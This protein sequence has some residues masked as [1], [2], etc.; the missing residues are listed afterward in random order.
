[1]KPDGEV[2]IDIKGNPTKFQIVKDSHPL[3]GKELW[4]ELGLIAWI[5]DVKIQD[6]D[7][8]RN[9][10]HKSEQL[11]SIFKDVFSGLGLIKSNAV[12]H[13]DKTVNPVIDPPRKIPFVI[14]DQVYDDLNRMIQLGVITEQVEP[15]E[16]VNSITIVKKPTS[17]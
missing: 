1:M 17:I 14:Q 8:N 2:T 13:I 10:N 15:T 16:W 12:I 4:V 9:N 7:V 3:L 5:D 11:V 6:A